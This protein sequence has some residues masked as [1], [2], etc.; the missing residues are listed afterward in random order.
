M[1]SPGPAGAVAPWK[2]IYTCLFTFKSFQANVQCRPSIWHAHT[3]NCEMS[4]LKNFALSDFC[5]FLNNKKLILLLTSLFVMKVRL[6]CDLYN[7][8]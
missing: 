1:E 3:N 7:E 5:T 4:S 6:C 8:I 2:K